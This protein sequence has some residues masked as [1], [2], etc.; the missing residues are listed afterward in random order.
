VLDKKYLLWVSICI[1]LLFPL[2]DL[3]HPGLPITHDGQDHVARIANF[4]QSLTEGTVVPR[5][6]ANLNWGYGHPILMFLYPLPSYL[7]SFF[8]FFGFS[9][10]DSLKVVFG[11]AFIAS[12]IT[13]YVWIKEMLGQEEGL[14]A[15]ALYMYAPYRFVDLYVRGA[16]GE[17]VAFVFPPLI[18]YFFLKLSKRYS[19][20]YVVFGSLSVAGLILSHNAITLMFLPF[21]LFYAGYLCWIHRDKRKQIVLSYCS[22]IVLGFGISAFFLIPAFFEGKYTLR[23]IVTKGEYQNRFVTSVSDFIYGVWNYGGTG[24]FSV[25]VGILQWASV[26]F[27][28]PTAI[29]LKKKKRD[30]IVL[31]TLCIAFWFVLFLMTTASKPIWEIITTMQK[32]QFPWRLLSLTVFITAVIGAFCISFLTKKIKTFILFLSIFLILFLN[33]EYWHA[34]GYMYKDDQF[35]KNIYFGTTDTG[36][37][38]PIWSVRFMEQP[39][40]SRTEIIG[41]EATVSEH[42]RTSTE[43]V[44]E[45]DVLT[46]KAQIREN[47]LYFPGWVV[48]VDNKPTIVEFQSQVNRGVMTFFLEKGKHIVTVQFLETKLRFI[49]NVISIASLATLLFSDILRRKLWQRFR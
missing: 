4:Y 25:Q 30:I 35:F 11:L 22:I 12:G 8:H 42:K 23:D 39:P 48:K 36:E 7:A 3:F 26:F 2:F 6:A 47:T 9:F 20:W 40:K 5:W 33:R 18:F 43:H 28:L 45:I 13:M 32:F 44:Y 34:N 15:G 31:V 46:D 19:Y 21:M 37:S 14:I 41:G 29:V 1:L 38:A 10:I 16:I 24:K 17:H 49:A 27:A